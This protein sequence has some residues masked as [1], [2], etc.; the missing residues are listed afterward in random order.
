[1]LTQRRERDAEIAEM[2]AAVQRMLDIQERDTAFSISGFT[3]D[4]RKAIR[5]FLAVAAML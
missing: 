4:I 1:M 3:K 5:C 2:E